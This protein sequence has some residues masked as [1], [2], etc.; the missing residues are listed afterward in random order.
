M[1]VA[2]RPEQYA[3]VPAEGQVEPTDSGSDTDSLEGQP[4][5]STID[6]SGMSVF[7]VP[8]KVHK[9][10]QP[11]DN[12]D[13]FSTIAINTVCK[14]IM[15]YVEEGDEAEEAGHE[16]EDSESDA[17]SALQTHSEFDHA[18]DAV[19]EAHSRASWQGNPRRGTHSTAQWMH[20]VVTACAE[21]RAFT[22]IMAV[23]IVVAFVATVALILMLTHVV[24]QF[25]MAVPVRNASHPSTQSWLDS[26]RSVVFGTPTTHAMPLAVPS[27][28]ELLAIDWDEQS[29]SCMCIFAGECHQGQLSD[30]GCTCPT[31]GKQ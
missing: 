21:S 25:D 11:D 15:P 2:S 28:A 5:E 6:D 9:R 26:S 12:D 14:E 19:D 29:N 23:S 10:Q 20:D 22:C 17:E 1:R 31:A 13:S 18:E 4:P 7:T 24:P 16:F 8:P 27:C 3:Q 30:T